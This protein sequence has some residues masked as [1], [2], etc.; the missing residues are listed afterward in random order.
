MPLWISVRKNALRTAG[1]IWNEEKTTVKRCS[2]GQVPVQSETI[3]T[4]CSV[5]LFGGTYV[6]FL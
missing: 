1:I 4:R 3:L 2:A 6:K 5:L